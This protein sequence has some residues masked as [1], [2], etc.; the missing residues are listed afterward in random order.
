[1]VQIPGFE[2]SFQK[3]QPRALNRQQ[4]NLLS[5][6]LPALPQSLPCCRGAEPTCRRQSVC[7]GEVVSVSGLGTLLT[8]GV[9]AGLCATV[10]QS[11]RGD[12]CISL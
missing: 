12:Y 1:M 7:L 5:Y 4:P 8:G 10:F 2:P 9:P 3:R 6:R 11:F